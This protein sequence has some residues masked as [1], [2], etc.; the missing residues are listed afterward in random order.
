MFA[1]VRPPFLLRDRRPV[2]QERATVPRVPEGLDALRWTDLA[3][4]LV[5]PFM[6]GIVGYPLAA[7]AALAHQRLVKQ[8]A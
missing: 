5:L 3:G 2:Q 6:M 7:V 4:A 1:R 8:P